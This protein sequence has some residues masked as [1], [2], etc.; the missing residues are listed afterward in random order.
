MPVLHLMCFYGICIDT[1]LVGAVVEVD[2]LPPLAGFTP[3][4]VGSQ[5]TYTNTSQRARVYDWHMGDGT[6]YNTVNVTH[7]YLQGGIYNVTL[8]AHNACGVDSFNIQ[9]LTAA[10]ALAEALNAMELYPNPSDG[11]FT[12]RLNMPSAQAILLTVMD[13]TG[14]VVAEHTE[15]VTSGVY[16]RTFDL[17][18]VP[19]GVYMLQLKSGDASVHRKLMIE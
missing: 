5:V 3:N 13:I 19:P 9:V 1:L 11:V 12:L 15:A 10:E 7:N 4:I 8:Y 14:K 16:H 18:S 2:S 6:R 17:S